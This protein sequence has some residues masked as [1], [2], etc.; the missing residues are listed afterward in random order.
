MEQFLSSG[1]VYF[2]EQDP[3]VSA[4]EFL[5]QN[6]RPGKVKRFFARIGFRIHLGKFKPH[7]MID[8]TSYFFTWCRSHEIYYVDYEHGDDWEVRCPYCEDEF[9]KNYKVCN[10]PK[11]RLVIEQDGDD[12]F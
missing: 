1:P 3:N 8:Y 9:L 5:L 6:R 7:G 12:L 10:D 4:E 2:F 11:L